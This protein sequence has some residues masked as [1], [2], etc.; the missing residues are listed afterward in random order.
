MK[1]VLGISHEAIGLAGRVNMMTIDIECWDQIFCR[2]LS[3]T[4]IP[5]SGKW[6]ESIRY[7][8]DLFEETGS[9]ATFFVLGCFAK[10]QPGLIR[11]I[12]DAG[13]E[14]GSHGYS[15]SRLTDLSPVSFR[16][17]VRQSKD[18]LEQITGAEVIGYRA[19]EF[20]I[21]RETLWAL[22]ILVEER[23]AYDTSI[24]PIY[25]GRYGIP[26]FP[27]GPVRLF[28]RA[29][30]IIEVPL[31][32]IVAAGRN[33]PVSGGGYARA[34]PYRLLA[35]AVSMVNQRGFPFVFYGH[36]Y[37]FAAGALSLPQLPLPVSR[38]A[39]W[40][41]ELRYNLLRSSMRPKIER[42]VRDFKFRSV[43]EVVVDAI[44]E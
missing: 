28:L 16:D 38:Y 42:L 20:T 11:L 4:H 3:G 7:L 40:K 32:T 9:A 6:G 29:G 26:G 34:L 30:D 33:W 18:V 24:F 14:I 36:P 10:D 17:E 25:H 41:V 43:R 1:E 13:H 39:S 27:G 23:I 21:V 15:H 35:R 22:D 2:K 8:L 5:A 44:Y 19:P 37:E 31:S 12:C